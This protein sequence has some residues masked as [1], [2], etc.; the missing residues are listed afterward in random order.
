MIEFLCIHC[1][2]KLPSEWDELTE[3]WFQQVTFLIHCEK[4]NSCSQRYYLAREDGKLVAA[5]I[6]YTLR[7]DIL[8]YLKIKSPLKMHIVGIP[9]SVSSEGIFGNKLEKEELK[10]HIYKV[11]KGFILILNLKE[12]NNYPSQISLKTLPTVVMSNHY[13]DWQHYINSLR[14]GYRRRLK[15]INQHDSELQFEKMLCSE[16]TET[17]YQQYLEVFKRSNGKL[18]KLSIDFF[19]HLPSDFILTVCSVSYT[20]LTLPTIYSV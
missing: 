16:F 3:N 19:K 11:E 18:E 15:L 1:A 17:M 4:Y 5:A 6:V 10:K 12:K 13:T 2:D 20:H 7:I 8:T 14:T 9:C